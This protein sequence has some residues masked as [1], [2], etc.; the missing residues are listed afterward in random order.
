MARLFPGRPVGIGPQPRWSCASP[1]LASCSMGTCIHP[2][3]DCCLYSSS[4]KQT[5]RERQHTAA[6]ASTAV[7]LLSLFFQ[8]AMRSCDHFVGAPILGMVQN[9]GRE[10]GLEGGGIVSIPPA[11][12]S[13]R[14][15][16]SNLHDD[17]V[18]HWMTANF[19]FRR[20]AANCAALKKDM[21]DES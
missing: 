18:A 21:T 1:L 2:D 15:K 4:P 12:C 16:D 8:R 11:V 19:S 17:C 13:W 10:A 5:E 6:Q 3:F 20:L 14:R 7:V 9:S